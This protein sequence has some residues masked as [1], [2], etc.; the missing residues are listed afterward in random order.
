MPTTRAVITELL[1]QRKIA[2]VGVSRSP[3]KFGGAAYRA[4]RAAGYRVFAVHPEAERL[5]G[6]PCYRNLASLPEPVGAVLAIVPPAKTEALVAEVA[7]AGIK[8]LWMQQG[9]ES[10]AAIAACEQAGIR[11][12][13]GECILMFAEPTPWFHRVHR[14]IRKVTQGLPA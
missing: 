12:V 6:D 7:A 9:A 11:Y 3:N 14:F 5:E 13:A 8:Y 10:P 1:A 2:V 4:L